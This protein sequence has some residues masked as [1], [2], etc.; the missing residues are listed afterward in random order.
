[1]DLN[2]YIL[3]ILRCLTSTNNLNINNQLIGQEDSFR[4]KL[5]D[6]DFIKINKKLI[7]ANNQNIEE[8]I[9]C[10]NKQVSTVI[11]INN[12]SNFISN[13]SGKITRI[14]HLGIS[15]SCISIDRELSYYKKLI[16]GT[17]LK[18]FEEKSDSIYNKWFFIGNLKKND[19][20]FEI[21]LTESPTSIINDWVPH[22]QIDFDTSLDYEAIVNSTENSL[23]K[24]FIKWKLNI[25]NYGTVLCM[26]ILGNI[27]GTKI[28]LGIGTNQRGKQSLKEI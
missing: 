16:S 13:I 14:N 28:T 26:G 6:K 23:A 25:P 8:K 18:L 9:I 24:D 17:S 2:N 1:M 27:N 7:V 22:F 21:V 11:D 15:Y 10:P 20:L 19:P 3:Q 12:I 4:L 5:S